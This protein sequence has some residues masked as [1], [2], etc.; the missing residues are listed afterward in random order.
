MVLAVLSSVTVAA[1][2]SVPVVAGWALPAAARWLACAATLA[3]AAWGVRAE[4][5]VA[6]IELH[7]DGQAWWWQEPGEP[8]PQPC[9]PQ[10]VADFGHWMLLRCAPSHGRR[11][12]RWLAL[13][14][15]VASAPPWHALRCAL[16]TS[17]LPQ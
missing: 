15:S 14:W 12:R 10:V 5:R 17:R 11:S 6:P 16:Y 7:W 13:Q 3:C 2:A 9:H 8:E 4:F 1:W